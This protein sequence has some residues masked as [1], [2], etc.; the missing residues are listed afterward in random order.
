MSVVA[1]AKIR[2]PP[3]LL[4]RFDS[5]DKAS[6]ARETGIVCRNLFI[7]SQGSIPSLA[8]VRV[9]E[10]LARSEILC[11]VAAASRRVG[12]QQFS[13]SPVPPAAYAL[14]DRPVRAR[15]RLHSDTSEPLSQLGRGAEVLALT[16]DESCS[17]R[18]KETA[19]K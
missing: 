4:K 6:T 11:L 2:A 7:A 14:L 12:S 18:S 19:W 13:R 5:I 15:R 16:I 3:R 9:R 10:A 1:V 8:T 17:T